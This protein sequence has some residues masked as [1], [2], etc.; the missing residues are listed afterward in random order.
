MRKALWRCFWFCLVLMFVFSAEKALSG[1]RAPLCFH[2]SF[3]AGDYPFTVHAADIDDD[4]LVDLIVGNLTQTDNLKIFRNIGGGDFELIQ[5]RTIDDCAALSVYAARLNDDSKDDLIVATGKDSVALL[6]YEDGGGGPFNNTVYYQGGQGCVSVYASDFDLDGDQD[7]AI[8]S[9]ETPQVTI[10]FNQEDEGENIFGDWDVYDLLGVVSRP[11]QIFAADLNHDGYPDV[12]VGSSLGP[13]I[14]LL[15]N[16]GGQ[17]PDSAGKFHT[18]S[19]IILDGAQPTSVWLGPL[20]DDPYNDI[21]VSFYGSGSM[22][23][24]FNDSQN[25]G[26]FPSREYFRLGYVPQFIIGADLDGENGNDVI[27]LNEGNPAEPGDLHVFFND[28]QGNFTLHNRVFLTEPSEVDPFSI[29]MC[30]ADFDADG[31]PDIA[32]VN[33]SAGKLSILLNSEELRGDVNHSGEIDLVDVVYL[34]NFLFQ[35]GPAPYTLCSADVN[36]DEEIG[37][38]DV[39][40]LLRYAFFEMS[41]TPGCSCD[42]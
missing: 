31:D 7:L 17:N 3:E 36:C 35:R 42:M 11:A 9:V 26:N 32:V 23:L 24:L 37:I 22:C 20:N 33:L 1:A 38:T 12:A 15:M 8:S 19:P 13:R 4:G 10:L 28:G 29:G 39:I 2:K 18:P 41:P 16:K 27:A 34:L 25:P 40:Y 6:V 5:T 30:S 14:A 21:A